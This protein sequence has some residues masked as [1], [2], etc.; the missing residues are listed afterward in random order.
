MKLTNILVPLIKEEFHLL[1]NWIH[2]CPSLCL[3]KEKE[4]ELNLHLSLDKNWNDY[5]KNI[6]S[7]HIQKSNLKNLNIFFISVGMSDSESVYLRSKPIKGNDKA[8]NELEYGYKNGPNKQFFHSI[9]KIIDKIKPTESDSVILLEVDTLIIKNNW[10]DHVNH[11]LEKLDSFWIAGSKPISY[12]KLDKSLE[13]HLNGNSIYGIGDLNFN[14]FL[15]TWKEIH[16]YISKSH[17]RLAYDCILS[18]FLNS[19]DES[20]NE[21]YKFLIDQY[22]KKLLNI[23]F[24]L[25]LVEPTINVKFL[26]KTESIGENTIIIHSKTLTVFAEG[27]SITDETDFN[28]YLKLKHPINKRFHLIDKNPISYFIEDEESTFDSEVADKIINDEKLYLN[29]YTNYLSNICLWVPP[30]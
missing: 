23:N 10:I 12:F 24:I 22:P 20:L 14:K 26:Q 30:S 8:F 5:D 11:E 21:K 13:D 27:L 2:N 4:K 25:N 17:K 19:K 1:I 6:L 7:N 3:D 29:K 16:L 18:F 15:E 9:E 28:K